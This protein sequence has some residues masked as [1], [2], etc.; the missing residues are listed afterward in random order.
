M[1]FL[2]PLFF[3]GT[4]LAQDPS[5]LTDVPERFRSNDLSASSHAIGEVCYGRLILPSGA[6]CN[7]AA[8]S[9]VE[10]PTFFASGA[11]QNGNDAYAMANDFIFQKIDSDAISK[12]FTSKRTQS[13]R[14]Q[15]G[16]MATVRNF[17]ASF[18]P[19]RVQF[20]S[21][22]DNPNYPAVALHASSERN[23][24]FS[25]GTSLSLLHRHLQFISVGVK[26]SW[27]ERQFIHQKF[28]LTEAVLT[29]LDSL[30]PIESQK[31]VLVDASVMVIPPFF[32]PIALSFAVTHIG[33]L[34]PYSIYY[35]QPTDLALGLS[36]SNELTLGKV[37]FSVD[38]RDFLYANQIAS[39]LYAGA[40]YQI[41]IVEIMGGWNKNAA[42][43]GA[44]IGFRS[45]FIALAYDTYQSD[46]METTANDR[47]SME[48]RISI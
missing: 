22:F 39:V 7:P 11:V 15:V 47:L 14:G 17:Q 20:A 29:P 34:K 46:L 21:Q 12:L 25:G 26:A 30:I 40:S 42:T 18:E 10:E 5:S 37:N 44:Q 3:L 35:Y 48:I 45:V 33:Q 27:I 43:L 19:Y 6:T 9:E 4:S 2:L 16:L 24:S 8:L 41:G 28:T 31:G 1:H 32:K 13:Y 23:L 38:I 36:F